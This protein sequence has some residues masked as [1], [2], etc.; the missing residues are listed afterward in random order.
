MYRNSG[1]NATFV[2]WDPLDS[3]LWTLDNS[4]DEEM[5]HFFKDLNRTTLD[6][7]ILAVNLL[8]EKDYNITITVNTTEGAV[9]TLTFNTQT[10]S[11]PDL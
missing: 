10:F 9:G 6:L 7:V 5:D 4:T 1:L 3:I 8:P 11:P 2:Y